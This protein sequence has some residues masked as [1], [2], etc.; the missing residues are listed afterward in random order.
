M[1]SLYN[2]IDYTPNSFNKSVSH[3]K[4]FN[5]EDPTS[6]KFQYNTNFRLMDTLALNNEDGI[7]IVNVKNKPY[8]N[9]DIEPTNGNP[10]KFT[11]INIPDKN[12]ITD[13]TVKTLFYNN[14][15]VVPTRKDLLIDQGNHDIYGN[16]YNDPILYDEYISNEIDGKLDKRLKREFVDKL[17]NNP[18][19]HISGSIQSDKFW[20]EDPTVLFK[21][22]NYYRILPSNSMSKIEMLNALT[23]FFIYLMLIYI[24]FSNNT[25]YVYIPIIAIIIIIMLYYIQKKDK[26]DNIQEEFCRGDKC[27]NIDIC[28][29]PTKGNPFMN[30]T[31]A[32][33]MDNPDRPP[34][35]MATD[36][37]IKEEI[38][39]NYNYNL[40]KD[41]DD[42]FDRG[43]S[44]RQF[45]TMPSTTIPNEQTTFA[46]W[47][48]KLPETCKENQSNCL[49]YEDIRFN[50][51]NP[52]IDRMERVQED[53]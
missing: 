7:D 24:M 11:D 53:L 29:K 49:K 4:R 41:V 6:P 20:L 50:R 19:F 21:N 52:N 43:Y 34:A 48:Y 1:S 30:V 31:M 14:P 26:V 28:Q 36:R 23:R 9:D 40:F 8:I 51:F 22:G 3:D 32:D 17:Q 37:T 2:V 38:D 12:K 44:Q 15:L 16:T 39:E 33:L 42:V 45:Y 35:C 5:Y 27:N 10:F 47:L 13:P 25:Q 46:K 18:D